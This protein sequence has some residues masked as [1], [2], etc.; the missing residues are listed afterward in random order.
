MIIKFLAN[1][2]KVCSIAHL[3]TFTRLKPDAVNVTVADFD[4]VLYHIANL[5]GDK[6]KLIVSIS[7]KFFKELQD[8][9]ADEVSLRLFQR[10]VNLI[11]RCWCF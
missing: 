8:H 2:I 9:G 1:L 10:S 5:D 6:S 3:D 11:I 7:L 4:G